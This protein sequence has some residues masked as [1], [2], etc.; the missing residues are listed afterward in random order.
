MLMLVGNAY[1]DC[2]GYEAFTIATTVVGGPIGG[3]TRISPEERSSSI[4]LYVVSSFI[5]TIG[6]ISFLFIRYVLT[7]ATGY[8]PVQIY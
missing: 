5:L 7:L 4:H 3:Q 1:V 8:M 6:N 2:N